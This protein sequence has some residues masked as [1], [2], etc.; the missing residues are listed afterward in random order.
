MPKEFIDLALYVSVMIALLK[1]GSL[2]LR[3]HQQ[4]YIQNHLETLTLKVDYLSPIRWLKSKKIKGNEHILLLFSFLNLIFISGI[5]FLYKE[6]DYKIYSIDLV[7]VTFIIL[8]AFWSLLFSLFF[9]LDKVAKDTVIAKTVLYLVTFHSLFSPSGA[10]FGLTNLY[11]GLIYVLVN[12]FQDGVLI[13]KSNMPESVSIF[14][15]ALLFSPMIMSLFLSIVVNI[16]VISGVLV[17][18]ICII[19]LDL[20]LRIVKALLWRIV[21][22]K[23]GA[24]EAIILLLLILLLIVKLFI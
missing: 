24:F 7:I 20:L 14:T 16:E 5:Y 11:S 12:Y 21:E 4:N 9:Y 13:S 8:S 10:L 23:S 2:F 19:L 15:V 6:I 1:G 3:K 22:Y 17:V 18:S